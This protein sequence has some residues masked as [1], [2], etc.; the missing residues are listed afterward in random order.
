M[1]YYVITIA[2][3]IGITIFY[4]NLKVNY[5]LDDLINKDEDKKKSIDTTNFWY[6]IL[7][8]SLV[9]VTQIAINIF[10]LINKCGTDGS[11]NGLNIQNAF[12]YTVLPWTLMF[13]VVL[14]LI[15]GS[16]DL[17][18]IFGNVFGYFAVQKKSNDV[19][20]ELLVGDQSL[21][22]S[23]SGETTTNKDQLI[24]AAD[25]IVRM[26]GNKSILVNQIHPGNFMEMWN[27]L[28]PLFKPG[29]DGEKQ[30]ELQQQLLEV[31][32][33]RQNVGEMSWY[34]YTGILVIFV[35]AYH[36]QTV[37]CEPTLNQLAK[38]E[39]KLQVERENEEQIEEEKKNM[40]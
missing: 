9:I 34:L 36:L 30:S 16:S 3:F 1:Q 8:Y 17:K 25:A 27:M 19:L 12:F 29:L 14:L 26:M 4:A 21:N 13:A 32:T 23:L 35:V 11:Q 6:L 22:E 10:Y 20:S 37:T 28:T 24:N 31:A 40:Q 5:A 7:Y 2:V 38:N 18:N 15:R 33:T 39:S